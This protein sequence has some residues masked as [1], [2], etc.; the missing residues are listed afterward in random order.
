MSALLRFCAWVCE[1]CRH[2]NPPWRF[3][4]RK[5]RTGRPT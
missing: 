1:A 3:E 4:C 5:C 2:H